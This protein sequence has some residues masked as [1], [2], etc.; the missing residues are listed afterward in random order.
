M[1]N[2]VVFSTVLAIFGIFFFVFPRQDV[3]DFE[4]R[5]LSPWPQYSLD[6]MLYG[7]YIDSIDLFAADHFPF[8]EELVELSFNLK[9]WRG[10][11]NDEIAFY[12]AADIKSNEP[13]KPIR[14]VD[15]VADTAGVV[16]DTTAG[17]PGEEVN[18]L[19]I[20]EG[21]AMEIFG[22]NCN[23]AQSYAKTINKYQA[24][25]GQTGVRIFDVAV[26]S[27]IEYFAP[28]QYKKQYST[29]KRNIDCVYAALDPAVKG[30]DA[31]S[32]IAAHTNEN[33]YFRTDHH[34][35]GL[36]A[37]YAYTAF[38]SSAGMTPL[39]LSEME[40]KQKTGYLGSLYWLTRDSRLKENPD[41]VDYWK[42]PGTY[43]T[44][45]Y[46]KGDQTKGFKGSIYAES[47][48]GANGYGVFL[49]G[50]WPLM[51]IENDVK[52]GK[53][54][55]LVKNSY[56]NPFG[57]YLPYHYETVYVI[58]YR[59]YTGSLK[60]LVIDEKI[61]DLIFLNGVFSINTSWHIQMVGK[62]MNGVG[63]SVPKNPPA[64][65]TK[66]KQ[67]SIIVKEKYDSV[68]KEPH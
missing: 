22:G 52:N 29:E 33:I 47:A 63:K 32:S 55:V 15:T 13:V 37:Y 58:D 26:P 8:R 62:I 9:D 24:E 42:I 12:N 7:K 1:I 54:C 28:N 67:D 17:P 31:Y 4:K 35:T 27:S 50:D 44:T 41:T 30:V 36:G 40:H 68:P 46:N 51:K 60:Q 53:K 64:D 6:S 19:F 38:C 11:K 61:T 39:Q 66:P 16:E 49:G 59:Y 20:V 65:T 34:W 21:R 18:N 5:K 56:G 23:M 48:S 14:A 2:T 45:C 3:S 57:T 10:I 25:L 43:K